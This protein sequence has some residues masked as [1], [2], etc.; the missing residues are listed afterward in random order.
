MLTINNLSVH[1]RQTLALDGATLT[2]DP[3]RIVGII[4]PNGAGKSTLIKAIL[5]LVPSTGTVTYEGR[6]LKSQ[7]RRVAYIPQR[8]AVDWDY[9]ATVHDVV[10][11][12]R[13]VHIGWLR[14]ASATDRKLV[15]EALERV[16]MEGFA[17]RQIGELSGGQQ[18]RVFIARA[19]AQQADLLF[20]DE[21]FVGVDQTTEAIIFQIFAQLRDQGKTLLVVNHDLGEAVSH[22]DDILLMRN[23]V[24]AFGPRA[25]VFNDT[26]L[27]LAYGSG[28][29]GRVLSGLPTTGMSSLPGDP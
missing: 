11:M 3:R 20:F 29:I 14:W 19:L 12:G 27:G 26:N 18:Q 10:M 2:I 17:E 6:P 15:V 7:L 4:G 9:P 24:V 23:R 22:Y 25:E 16:G 13:C 28:A 21:P 1:Y 5:E 8:T